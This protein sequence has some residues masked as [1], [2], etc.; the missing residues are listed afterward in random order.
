MN[1]WNNN[2]NKSDFASGLKLKPTKNCK[3]EKL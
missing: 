3:S 2:Y 1:M